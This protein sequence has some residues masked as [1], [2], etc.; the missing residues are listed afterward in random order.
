MTGIDSI[1]RGAALQFARRTMS[2]IPARD[3]R[4]KG[5]AGARCLV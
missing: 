1:L 2:Q 5:M 3:N 4:T